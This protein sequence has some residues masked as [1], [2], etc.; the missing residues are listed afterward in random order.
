MCTAIICRL[1]ASSVVDSIS[2]NEKGPPLPER[3]L[4]Q[5]EDNSLRSVRTNSQ[6]CSLE[7]QPSVHR[8]AGWRSEVWQRHQILQVVSESVQHIRMG[9]VVG[10]SLLRIAH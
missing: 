4:R 7:A 10:E 6:R 1:S 3:A 8:R 9:A 2:L 5:G